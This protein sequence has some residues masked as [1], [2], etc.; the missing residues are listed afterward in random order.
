MNRCKFTVAFLI[1]IVFSFSA[2]SR[3]ALETPD[4]VARTIAKT[5]IN[6]DKKA[7]GQHVVDRDGYI[8]IMELQLNSEKTLGEGAQRIAQLKPIKDLP[9]VLSSLKTA[10]H[11]KRKKVVR[12]NA[13]INKSFERLLQ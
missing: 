1:I 4:G 11:K 2:C 3:K 9:Q 13:S 5:I 10:Q 6:Q 12:I 7:F 8:R